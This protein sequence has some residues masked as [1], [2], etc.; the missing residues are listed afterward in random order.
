VKGLLITALA[1]LG[2][3][4][5][6]MVK[7]DLEDEKV[8][9]WL[10][11][12]LA[13]RTA[14]RLPADERDRWR[15]ELIRD[16][17]DLEGR[18]APLLWALSTYLQAGR[19]GRERGVPSR[20]EM[21]VI[22]VRLAWYRLQSLSAR[23]ARALSKQHHPSRNRDTAQEIMATGIDVAE[24]VATAVIASGMVAVGTTRSSGIANLGW[25][26]GMMHLSD[27][28]FIRWLS[29]QRQAFEGDI[30]RQ[31]EEYRRQRDRELG[32]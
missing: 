11:R 6:G 31:V 29:Q 27:H 9:R 12:K 18:V 10:A 19:W 32:L 5:L 30:D 22:R 8:C 13:Y 24:A 21:L 28:D 2:A 3:L 17:L 25:R 23:R 4:L 26:G 20:S 16:L 14:Q 15:E 1:A 7:A